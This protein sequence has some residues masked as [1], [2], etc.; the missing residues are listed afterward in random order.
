MEAKIKTR[1][2]VFGGTFDPPHQ[3]HM[4]MVDNVLFHGYADRCIMVP[5]LNPPHKSGLPVSAFAHRLKMLELAAAGREN[6]IISE[7]EN[8]D[9]SEPS[10]TYLTLMAC[11]K[12][13]PAAEIILLLGSDSLLQLHTWYRAED[14]VVGFKLLSYPRKNA[15]ELSLLEQIWPPDLGEKLK[16][17]LLSL[18]PC[19]GIAT[20]LRCRIADGMN[21]G[22]DL[23]HPDVLHY[24]HQHALYNTNQTTE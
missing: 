24:I 17:S 19:P 9:S 7:I 15:L 14:I 18:L 21:P 5:A 23:I 8:T 22:S 1:I 10:Y 16:D 13:N 6:I 12:E 2:V 11:K 4:K 20:D 3:G